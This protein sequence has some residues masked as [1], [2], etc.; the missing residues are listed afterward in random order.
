MKIM[1]NLIY[2][3]WLKRFHVDRLTWKDL[4]NDF[5][6]FHYRYVFPYYDTLYTLEKLS[7]KGFQ[8]VLSQL[9]NLKIKRFRLHSLGLMHVI[10]YLSTSETVGFRKPHPKIFEDMIDQLGVLPEQENCVCWR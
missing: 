9:V 1:I 5:E 6:M 4:F 2:I 10:N 7:Q 8:M 3:E